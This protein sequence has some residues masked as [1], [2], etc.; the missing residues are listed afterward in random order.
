[1]NKRLILSFALFFSAMVV[2]AGGQKDTGTS[3]EV[4]AQVPQRTVAGTIAVL[5][6][7]DYLGV[8]VVALPN[9]RREIDP[10]FESKFRIGMPMK[11][12]MEKLKAAKPDFFITVTSLQASLEP[13]LKTANIKSVFLNTSNYKSFLESMKYLG[14]VYKKEAKADAYISQIKKSIE[15]VTAK[16]KGKKAPTVLVIFGTPSSMSFATSHSFVGSLVEALGGKN[17]WTDAS[18]PM[19]YAPINLELVKAA[20]PDII[21]RFAHVKPAESKKAYEKEF[22]NAFWTKLDA[23]KNGRV[24]DLGSKNFTVSGNIR[25]PEALEELSKYMYG[26]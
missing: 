20:N 9:T 25:V 14:K 19:P 16:N 8:D 26:N 23:V 3:Y 7:L 13:Q 22:K 6:M 24:Y 2:F 11:P 12:N 18:K 10:K 1:M 21:L 4:P 5:E 15:K 17:V